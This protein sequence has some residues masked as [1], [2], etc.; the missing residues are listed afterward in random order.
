MWC[1]YYKWEVKRCVLLP[2]NIMFK[3]LKVIA[4][5]VPTVKNKRGKGFIDV[6]LLSRGAIISYVRLAQL[7]IPV[8]PPNLMTPALDC[9]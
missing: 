6:L 9:R 1:T 5:K 4:I 8:S 3:I 2:R 7:L